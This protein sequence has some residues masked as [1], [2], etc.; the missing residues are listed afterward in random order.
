MTTHTGVAARGQLA[1][2]GTTERVELLD[3]LRGF[4]LL[5]I[6]LVNFEG[7]TNASMSTADSVVG[8]TLNVL[9]SGSF[10]PLF[11]FLFGLGFAVQLLRARERGAGVVRIYLRRMLALFLIGTFHAVLIWDGDILVI[12]SILGLLLIPLHRL[13]D[14]WLLPIP[15][16]ILALNLY[17]TQVRS[18]TEG[19][20]AGPSGAAL[21]E[22]H[23][24]ARGDETRIENVLQQ[25]IA[26]QPEVARVEAYAATVRINWRLYAGK[27]RNRLSR[28][29]FLGDILPFFMLGLIVG[30]RRIL[31]EAHRHRKALA[32]TAGIAAAVAIAGNLV[33]YLVEPT[34]QLLRGLAYNGQNYGATVFYIAAISA[35]FV[36][37]PR[38]ARASRIFAAP[39]AIGLTNYLIQSV[40]MT[41]L[42]AKYGVGLDEPRALVWLAL[43]VAFFFAV[44]VPVSRWWTARYR[45]GPAEWAWRSMTYG[46]LQPMGREAPAVAEPGVVLPAS[47]R[48]MGVP[49]TGSSERSTTQRS[50]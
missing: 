25:R 33:V 12:Y 14:R 17:G 37:L 40:V 28:S 27:V 23:Q 47:A 13:R 24:V 49:A 19:L 41:L 7:D 15:I 18:F 38:V 6:L 21:R 11:S 31:Q 10:Y 36:S 32:W 34:A 29:F 5:G 26:T 50:V 8:T 44:Q 4:A 43:N 2:V 35:A 1:P 45:F 42:F 16:A 39:G 22:L 48:G 9:V 30:R 46:E 20:G 3:V